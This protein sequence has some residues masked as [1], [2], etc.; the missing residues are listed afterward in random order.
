MNYHSLK[1]LCPSSNNMVVETTCQRRVEYT[2]SRRF[3]RKRYKENELIRWHISRRMFGFSSFWNSEN[4]IKWERQ[5][6]ISGEGINVNSPAVVL[7]GN[8]TK[9]L[10]SLQFQK[11]LKFPKVHFADLKNDIPSNFEVLIGTQIDEPVP[12]GKKWNIV[13]FS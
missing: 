11:T 9:P 7:R 12:I 6:P 2:R 8:I 1:Q 10:T 3:A 13:N 4:L 5:N